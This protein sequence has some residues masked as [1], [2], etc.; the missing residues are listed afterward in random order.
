MT[1]KN[2]LCIPSFKQDILSVQSVI[3]NG[4][5]IHFS[6]ESAELRASDRSKF[7]I[8]K[9]GKLYYLHSVKG[10]RAHSLDQ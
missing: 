6:P 10:T 3:Q 5:S 7:N 9:S 4:S 1:L 8:K 2:A